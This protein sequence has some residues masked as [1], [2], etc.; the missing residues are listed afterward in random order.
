MR[1][2]STCKTFKFVL[3]SWQWFKMQI[4]R[5]NHNRVFQP[6]AVT[7]YFKCTSDCGV[8]LKT[9]ININ[10][11]VWNFASV[12]VDNFHGLKK[13]RRGEWEGR[14]GKQWEELLIM[15]PSLHS[16]CWHYAGQLLR[17]EAPAIMP[18]RTSLGTVGTMLDNNSRT[19]TDL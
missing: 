4:C 7:K 11:L 8:F 1:K 17:Q 10:S 16:D 19:L 12:T 2:V 15:P 9:F 18:K 5:M 14:W 13:G 6:I 3:M